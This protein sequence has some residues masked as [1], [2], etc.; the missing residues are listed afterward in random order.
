MKWRLINFLETTKHKAWVFWYMMRVC[1]SLF[2]RAIRH[3]MSK[4]SRYE[5]PYFE[6]SLPLLRSLEYGS[7]E[8]KAAIESLG[9]ALQHHYEMNSHHPEHHSV[10]GID[11]MTLLDQIEMLCDWKAAGKRH[12][13]GSMGKSLEVNA[14]RF[15]MPFARIAIYKLDCYEI[16]LLRPD[17]P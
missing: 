6:R 7:P 16:G 4:Y 13:T 9:P 17:K 5:A 11:A 12:K 10:Y 15:N 8:Y 3:D 14:T 2:R 1:W